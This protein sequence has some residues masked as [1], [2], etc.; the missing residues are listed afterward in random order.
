MVWFEY[1]VLCKNFA[2]LDHI[3]SSSESQ[4]MSMSASF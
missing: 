4:S 2:L 3:S 1:F